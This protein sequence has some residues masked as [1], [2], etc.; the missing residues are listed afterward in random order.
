M[1]DSAAPENEPGGANDAAPAGK[2]TGWRAL[3][4]RLY[5]RVPQRHVLAAVTGQAFASGTN[6]G[7]GVIIGRLCGKEEYGLYYLGFTLLIFVIELQNALISTPYMVYAPRL[8]ANEHRRYTG[9]T[10]IYQL[11]LSMAVMAA[12]AV[13][14]VALSFGA[15]PEG[16]APVAW[17]LLAVIGLVTLRDFTRRVCFANLRMAAALCID[18][19]VAALQLGT[20]FVLGWLGALSAARAW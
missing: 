13:A 18:A 15:G 16:L 12:L 19:S 5:E 17:S 1:S 8:E 20:L 9:S 14:A 4:A 2:P 6:F 7:T 3:P 10:L 11:G